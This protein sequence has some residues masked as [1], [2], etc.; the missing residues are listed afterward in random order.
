MDKKGMEMKFVRRFSLADR[1][2]HWWY[3]AGLVILLISGIVMY[4]IGAPSGSIQKVSH[5]TGGL[6]FFFAPV[7]YLY[8][9]K[10]KRKNWLF[11]FKWENKDLEWFKGLINGKK[12]AQ[13]KYTTGQK[14]LFLVVV[15][16][17]IVSSVTGFILLFKL[18][19]DSKELTLLFHNISTW[20]LGI[21]FLFHASFYFF[22]K[23]NRRALR[24]MIKGI[25]DVKYAEEN[26]KLWFAKV[27]DTA[28]SPSDGMNP[29]KKLQ[30]VNK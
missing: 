16:V 17:S 18:F 2:L 27:K 30:S 1:R 5:L 26:H 7:I 25:M 11:I 15:L 29:S 12:P 22:Y 21:Y 9:A 14:F 10:E 23:P 13:G 28:F 4:F 20:I 24:S 6:L 3:S 8:K 19:S